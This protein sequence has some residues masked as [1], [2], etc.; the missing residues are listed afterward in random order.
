MTKY[1]DDA[2]VCSTVLSEFELGNAWGGNTV[3][4]VIF[5]HHGIFSSG[6]F[7]Y[8]AFY[9]NEVTL[10]VV[11]RDLIDGQVSLGKIEGRFH[12]QDAH[13]SISLGIDREYRLHICYDHHS[14]QLRYRRAESPHSVVDWS[15][16]VPMTG[17]NESKV[18]Y[19]TFILPD[20][21]SPLLII[22]RSGSAENGAIL[23]KSFDE[24]KD[25]WED[26]P[27]EVLTGQ[28]LKPWTS[29]AY[30]NHPAIDSKGRIHLSYVWR[31]HSLGK[32]R[33]VNNLNI[34]Y[35]R[36]DDRGSSWKTSMGHEYRLPITPV[37]SETV[38]AIAPGSN[39]I[40]Q[41]GMTVDNNDRPHIVFY[42]NDQDGIPQYR[43]LWFDGKKWC[44]RYL[45][46]RANAF[47]LKGGGTLQI[48]IS[49]PE[50]V[51]DDDGNSFV[52]F[53]ADFTA[54]RLSMYVLRAPDYES[55]EIDL[56]TLWEESVGFAEPVIDRARWKNEKVLSILIQHNDQ[57]DHD[58]NHSQTLKPIKI[59]DF[60]IVVE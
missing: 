44:H 52:I 6:R 36:S 23:V 27:E 56:V 11:R 5:R 20:R 57:P 21:D 59:V 34:G 46:S 43:Y 15:D 9:E 30:L 55:C 45:S 35:G 17:N 41:C 48:P 42:S 7:Q 16:E 13:N 38:L 50:I 18:T 37:N 29:N 60:K 22:Y 14:T 4:T 19:P 10:R 26:Y 25:E 12:L 3:N 24:N 33:L 31:T 28:N 32:E 53:R 54:D 8:A 39:L 51:I 49:R 47:T 1:S 58:G 2:R 40:N